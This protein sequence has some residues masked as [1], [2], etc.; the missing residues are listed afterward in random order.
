MKMTANSAYYSKI[1]VEY[2]FDFFLLCF[3][4]DSHGM[5]MLVVLF[6]NTN[7]L[8]SPYSSSL[9][10][11]SG[12]VCPYKEHDCKVGVVTSL[13]LEA[14]KLLRQILKSKV[15]INVRHKVMNFQM[16]FFNSQV[17]QSL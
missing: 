16:K 12:F 9:Q 2:V 11:H 5:V 7:Y 3:V 10:S 13:K 8:S 1:Y 14:A 15:T 6:G 17:L 4:Q